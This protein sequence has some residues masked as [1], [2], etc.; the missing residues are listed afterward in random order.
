MNLTKECTDLKQVVPQTVLNIAYNI[1]EHSMK[2]R[3][4]KAKENI[5]K[6][7]T[8]YRSYTGITKI[9]RI[10]HEPKEDGVAE[11]LN[12]GLAQKARV[13]YSYV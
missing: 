8:T 10:A 3:S 7:T 9:T 12:K 6:S 13:A 4:D 1:N 11:R 5:S 2:F